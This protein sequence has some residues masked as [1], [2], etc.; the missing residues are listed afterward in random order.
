MQWLRG[1]EPCGAEEFK[2]KSV[3]RNNNTATKKE[4]NGIQNARAKAQRDHAACTTAQESFSE[5]HEA[6]LSSG[7][8]CHESTGHKY[9]SPKDV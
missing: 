2:D 3:A 7:R 9:R 8:D 4:E 6:F 5:G 1:R